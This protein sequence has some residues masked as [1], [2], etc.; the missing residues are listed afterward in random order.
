MPSRSE[1]SVDGKQSALATSLVIVLLLLASLPAVA[2]GQETYL[3]GFDDR[4]IAANPMPKQNHCRDPN[5]ITD[6]QGI[7]DHVTSGKA[8]RCPNFS[9]ATMAGTVNAYYDLSSGEF[10]VDVSNTPP[11]ATALTIP[12][13]LPVGIAVSPPSAMPALSGDAGLTADCEECPP[14]TIFYAQCAFLF[15]DTCAAN[16]LYGAAFDLAASPPAGSQQAPPTATLP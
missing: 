2:K 11:L 7:V 1:T 10:D 15:E 9:L 16:P 13:A 3:V 8:I 14:P 4:T 6:P 12:S 5:N